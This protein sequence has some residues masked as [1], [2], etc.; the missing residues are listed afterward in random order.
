MLLWIR[1]PFPHWDHGAVLGQK[2]KDGIPP[3]PEQV[4]FSLCMRANL[5]L[6][7]TLFIQTEAAGWFSHPCV[8]RY[9]NFVLKEDC[10]T[11]A[12]GGVFVTPLS[13]F[14]S[15][16]VGVRTREIVSLIQ[17]HTASKGPHGIGTQNPSFSP[18]GSASLIIVIPLDKCDHHR[19]STM[20]QPFK[21]GIN[22]IYR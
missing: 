3:T 13:Y 1:D 10:P 15:L 2:Q 6:L 22:S 4:S 14:L 19:A 18:A 16:V 9:I 12:S 5:P 11:P 20:D 17:H 8:C 7:S 21:I